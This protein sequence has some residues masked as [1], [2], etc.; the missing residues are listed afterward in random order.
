MMLKNLKLLLLFILFSTRI[1][2][3]SCTTAPGLITTSVVC[4][5]ASGNYA[6][7]G[8]VYYRITDFESPTT[9]EYR[10]YSYSIS[11]SMDNF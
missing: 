8:K 6:T 2:G 7:T 5:D 4:K 11:P 9:V 1:F 3:Y 10:V